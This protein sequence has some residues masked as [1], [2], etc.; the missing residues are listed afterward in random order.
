M[1]PADPR[2][3]TVSGDAWPLLAPSADD[4]NWRDVAN[5]LARI[6]GHAGKLAEDVVHY[7]LAEHACRVADILPVDLRLPGLLNGAH[8]AFT[9]PL[10]DSQRQALAALGAGT[11]LTVFADIQ[12]RALFAAAG[13]PYPVPDAA[14]R[15]I[16]M[17]VLRLR[18]TE[19]RDV[20]AEAPAGI[21]SSCWG[22]LPDPLPEIIIPWPF[23]LAT[24]QWL[25]RLY[26]W[27]PLPLAQA[28]RENGIL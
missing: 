25:M 15:Q 21:A 2:L 18:A 10:T 3:P 26:R 16:G 13:Q 19:R 20:M 22:A 24:D 1:S 5:T 27:L 9:G 14:A 6:C 23:H 12:D 28:A 17:A 8:A 7:S 11:A 4:V